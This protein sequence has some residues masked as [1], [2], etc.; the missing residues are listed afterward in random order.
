MGTQLAPVHREVWPGLFT[1]VGRT[2]AGENSSF[3]WSNPIMFQGCRSSH[4]ACLGMSQRQ[5][6]MPQHYATAM[7][8]RL[9]S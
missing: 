2:H 9:P 6:D 1:D 4:I 5:P 3:A 7:P 8:T